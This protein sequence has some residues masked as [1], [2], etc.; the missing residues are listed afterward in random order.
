MEDVLRKIAEDAIKDAVSDIL[1]DIVSDTVRDAVS[2][3]LDDTVQNAV[4]DAVSD[5]EDEI[6]TMLRKIAN[7][8]AIF[9]RIDKLE[10]KV[11]SIIAL[12]DTTDQRVTLAHER[13]DALVEYILAR[14]QI[15]AST[16]E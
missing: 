2:D 16:S 11:N 1:D 8:E 3:I 10:S 15:P 9:S 4:L 13:Q 6:D 5:I 14:H 12:I 7:L